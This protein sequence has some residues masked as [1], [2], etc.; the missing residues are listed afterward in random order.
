MIDHKSKYKEVLQKYIPADSLDIIADWILRFNFNLKITEGRL[1]KL[2]DYRS[3]LRKDRHLITINHNLNKYSFLITLVHEIAHLTTFEK[4]KVA[5]RRILPH[6]AEWKTEYKN[7]M[8]YFMKT[9]IFPEDVLTALNSYM[10]NPAASSCSD[11][12]LLRVLRKYDSKKNTS[13]HLEDI[14]VGSTFKYGKDRYFTK[15]ARIRKR[16]TCYEVGTKRVYL[17]SPLAEVHLV[18]QPLFNES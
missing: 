10:K 12:N 2:G 5:Y 11:E 13:V 8:Q 3:P 15:G 7:L 17:F 16:F 18:A 14:P 6:G 9:E 1:T 4:H